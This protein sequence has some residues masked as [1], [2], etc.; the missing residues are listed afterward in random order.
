MPLADFGAHELAGTGE[1]KALRRRAM[2]LQLELS[3]AG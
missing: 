2:R 3:R 1:L